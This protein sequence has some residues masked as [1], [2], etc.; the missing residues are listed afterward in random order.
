MT[1]KKL[2]CKG[3]PYRFSGLRDPSLD[4]KNLTTLYN[5]ITRNKDDLKQTKEKTF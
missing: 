4:R 5:R 1:Y 2:N 3:G